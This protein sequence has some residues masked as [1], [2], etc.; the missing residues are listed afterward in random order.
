MEDAASVNLR[1]AEWG[2]GEEG[3]R[4]CRV[5]AGVLGASALVQRY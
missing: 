3:V 2:G 5:L 4:G 1:V